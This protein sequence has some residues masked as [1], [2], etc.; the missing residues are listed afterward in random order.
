MTVKSMRW[1]ARAA[2]VTSGVV[3][4]VLL[5]Q[6][7][8]STAAEWRY[9]SRAESATDAIGNLHDLRTSEHV[10]AIGFHRHSHECVLHEMW[11]ESG[12]L[13]SAGREPYS[14]ISAQVEST[15]RGHPQPRPQGGSQPPCHSHLH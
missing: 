14:L 8:D 1:L 7:G 15:V 12:A 6:P 4:A 13:N 11:I 2:L 3:E 9:S 5:S 10:D